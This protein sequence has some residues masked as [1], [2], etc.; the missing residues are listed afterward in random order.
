MEGVQHGPELAAKNMLPNARSTHRGSRLLPR[1]FTI[2][3]LRRRSCSTRRV[4]RVSRQRRT[5][6]VRTKPFAGTRNQRSRKQP[7]M[8]AALGRTVLVER[9]TGKVGIKPIRRRTGAAVAGHLTSRF[10][11]HARS[12]CSYRVGRQSGDPA[13][14]VD[15]S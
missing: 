12:C 2:G 5:S 13:Q 10:G 15:S 6:T 9:H 7:I 11:H 3:A 8:I 4:Q 14:S 1:N